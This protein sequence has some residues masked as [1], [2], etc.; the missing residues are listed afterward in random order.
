[1]KRTVGLSALVLAVTMFVYGQDQKN[2]VE[3]MG[4]ICNSSCVKHD[5]PVATCD[6]GCKEKSGDV[7]FIDEKGNITKISNPEKVKGHMGKKMKM[8]CH[9]MKDGTMQVDQLLGIYGG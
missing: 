1:M 6:G 7:V 3:Q 5:Q 9:M 4:W 2:S 8:K